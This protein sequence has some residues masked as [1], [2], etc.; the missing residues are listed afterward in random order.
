MTT[1][2]F[3][4]LAQDLVK[5][6]GED[7]QL[8]VFVVDKA[9]IESAMDDLSFHYELNDDR[10]QYIMENVVEVVNFEFDQ[11]I[12]QILSDAEDM[13]GIDEEEDE[14]EDE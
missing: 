2:Q 10:L 14:D 8:A 12:N 6:H 11:T 13:F 9:D 7:E 4:E 1:K 3:L 5:K